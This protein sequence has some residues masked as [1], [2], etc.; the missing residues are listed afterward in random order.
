WGLF[1]FKYL[2]QTPEIAAVLGAGCV[3]VALGLWA[4]RLRPEVKP[5]LERS[6]VCV[7][8]G[9]LVMF[10]GWVILIPGA[11]GYSP[12]AVGDGNRINVVAG[13][14]IVVVLYGAVTAAAELISI[15]TIAPIAPI[16][17][18]RRRRPRSGAV[19][20]VGLIFVGSGYLYRLE[21]DIDTRDG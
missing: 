12:G 16:A 21:H 7:A 15:A 14:G 17:P 6:L 2:G 13:F 19:A 18:G 8:A 10:A 1:P 9:L 11:L 3:L 20:A 5:S 4:V